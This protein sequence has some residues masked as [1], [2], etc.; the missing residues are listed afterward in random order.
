MFKDIK[1]HNNIYYKKQILNYDMIEN[2]E[3]KKLNL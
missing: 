2:N 1:N 3:F